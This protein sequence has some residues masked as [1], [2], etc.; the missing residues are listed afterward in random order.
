ML[1]FL[2]RLITRPR[3]PRLYAVVFDNG[4]KMSLFHGVAYDMED[5]LTRSQEKFKEPYKFTDIKIWDMHTVEEVADEL[6][7][8]DT[9][10]AGVDTNSVMKKI[11]FTGDRK[12]YEEEKGKFSP[13]EQKYIEEKFNSNDHI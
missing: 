13:E 1:E 7:Y 10:E 4:S 8:T 12:L 6:F 9:V 3:P 5:V 11:I 2:K